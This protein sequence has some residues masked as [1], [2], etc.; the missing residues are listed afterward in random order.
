MRPTRS[1]STAALP[2]IERDGAR[3]RWRDEGAGRPWLLMHGWA[4][5]LDVWGPVSDVL[6]GAARVLRFDRR[7][8]GESTGEPSLAADAADALAVL[9]AAGVAQC[10]IVGMSQGARV[11]AMLAREHPARVSHVVLDGAPALEGLADDDHE[12]E[13]PLQRYRDAL[14]SGGHAALAA[15]LERHPLLQ[16]QRPTDTSTAL[17]HR[18]LLR[19]PATDLAVRRATPP[20]RAPADATFTQPTLIVNG[21]HDSRVRLR[22]GASLARALPRATREVLADCGHL[23]CLDDPAG[24]V[25]AL[26]DFL[27][28]TPE[29]A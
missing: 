29:S 16:L 24:Y 1:H 11:A 27:S 20:H 12:P 2:R 26:V 3:L 19:Y 18:L 10:A 6:A 8:Y 23:A 7:G 13:F 21:G 25:T 9:D 15:L 4:L 14:A 28:R 5:D 17:L 22:I